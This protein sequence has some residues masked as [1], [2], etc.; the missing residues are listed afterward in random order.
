MIRPKARKPVKIRRVE[1]LDE[2]SPF[3]QRLFDLDQIEELLRASA[4]E[5]RRISYS[6]TLDALG[7]QF[8]RPKMRALCV[9]LSEIDRRAG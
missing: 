4:R 2:P 5:G 9:A 6:E 1:E 7:Y 8:S 3:W